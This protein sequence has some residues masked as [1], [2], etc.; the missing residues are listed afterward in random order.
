MKQLFQDVASGEVLLL[1]GPDPLPRGR[2]VVVR[3]RY[4]AISP[5]TERMLRDFARAGLV[6]KA[7]QQPERVRQLLGRIRTE[8]VVGTLEAVRAKLAEPMP[9][10]Y[11]NAGVVVGTGREVTSFRP[12]DRVASNGP[13]ADTVRIGQNLCARVPDGVSDR[14]AAFVPLASI[15][16]QSLRL[17]APAL[18]E[19]VVVLGLGVVGLLVVQ[20]LRAAGCRVVGADFSKPRLDLAARW[21]AHALDLSGADPVPVVLEITGGHGADAVII[22]AATSSNDPVIQAAKMSRQQGRIVLV[23]VSGLTLERDEFFKKELTFQVSRSYGPGRYDPVYEDQGVD[24]P[25]GY[26]RWTEQRNFEAV[27]ALMAERRLETEPMISRVVPFLEAA[28]A[29][30]ALANDTAALALLLEYPDQPAPPQVRVP[31]APSPAA[32]ATEPAVGLIGAG[33]FGRRV[34]LPA[35]RE[36]GATLKVLSASGGSEAAMAA[37]QFS[38]ERSVA[39]PH[40]ALAEPGLNTVFIATRHAAHADL[41]AAALGRGL[42]VFVEKPLAIDEEGLARVEA[43]ARAGEGRLLMVGFN[44]RFSPHVQRMKEL[45]DGRGGSLTAV[46]T[47]NAGDVPGGHWVHDPAEGGGRIVGEGCHF[48]DLLRHLVGHP[49]TAVTAVEARTPQ[50]D[51]APDRITITLSFGDGSIGTL[52]Y[53]AGGHG[54]HPKERVEVYGGGRVLVLDDFRLLTGHGFG[55]FSKLK[56]WRREKGHREEVTAFLDAV[57]EGRPSPIPL[58]ELLEVTRAS[59]AAVEAAR[60][61]ATVL[62]APG[63]S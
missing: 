60:T 38:V 57:R 49:I 59:F 54:D 9:L 30:D 58:G 25:I 48:I 61:G 56:T 36:A 42:H 29:Y 47:V 10:G 26:V 11:C 15:A 45:L 43:A 24:Y 52:H 3:S 53:F 41:A 23:G 35:L 17:A 1:D 22:A 63:Q 7:R 28:R 32:R 34:L 40:E 19:T 37:R 33:Q 5:G 21:G 62:L 6:G 55:R 51:P 20:L 12:G 13:H 2:S 31:S 27:L 44:R 46:V 18:G 14:E 8:G 4:T 39:D 16:L 50:G